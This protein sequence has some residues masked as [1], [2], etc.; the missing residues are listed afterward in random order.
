MT[1]DLPFKPMLGASI[2]SL[3]KLKW[4]LICSVK[5]DGI[6]ATTTP[7]GPR[8]RSLKPVPN[9]HIRDILSSLP[10]FLDGEICFVRPDGSVDFRATASAVMSQSGTPN[11]TF[12]VFD[13]VIQNLGFA[14]RLMMMRRQPWFAELS[15]HPNVTI[16][17][18][19]T[20]TNPAE[21]YQMFADARALDHEG[22]ILRNPEGHYKFGRSTLKE[23]GLLKMKPWE[24]AEATVIDC[25]EEMFNANE[26]QT[27]ETGHTKRSSHQ[28]NKIPKG[29]M[30]TLVV[31]SPLW[32]KS[33]EIGT[34]FTAADR[35]AFWDH[36]PIG[37]TVKFSYIA[38]GDYDVPRHAVFK[39][40][41][42]AEDMDP[43]NA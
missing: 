22:L 41:R 27:S 16:L 21:A 37:K 11:F 32:P 4:P 12:M 17:S 42:P 28:E 20:L 18:Q 14:D 13:Y 23:Q 15:E 1:Y 33:F 36:K 7:D 40:F 19:K 24:D 39:G 8:T 9:R 26:A 34:G 3:E 29:R 5:L 25:T 31:Q 2:D 6:R 38:A 30:G 10:S 43:T 35:Q